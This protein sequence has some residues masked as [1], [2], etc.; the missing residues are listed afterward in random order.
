MFHDAPGTG[1]QGR[2]LQNLERL[3]GS[4]HDKTTVVSR[5]I[6]KTASSAV[7]MAGGYVPSPP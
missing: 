2:L 7:A 1:L 4:A 5:Q 3:K 6:G